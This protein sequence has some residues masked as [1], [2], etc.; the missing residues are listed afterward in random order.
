MKI[1]EFIVNLI[2]MSGNLCI[3]SIGVIGGLI[4]LYYI[5][6]TFNLS[7]D[8]RSDSMKPI[9]IFKILNDDI[10]TLNMKNDERSLSSIIDMVISLKNINHRFTKT[11]IL[12][13]DD[14]NPDSINGRPLRNSMIV[15][16]NVGTN[17]LRIPYMGIGQSLDVKLDIEDLDVLEFHYTYKTDHNIFVD[18]K[19]YIDCTVLNDNLSL[20]IK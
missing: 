4:G 19:V 9:L 10:I 14:S 20:T 2:D 6:R 12:K 1:L 13:I 18:K 5:I 16:E 17:V 8:V 15:V 7:V 11:D 3:N